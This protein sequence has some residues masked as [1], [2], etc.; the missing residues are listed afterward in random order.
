MQTLLQCMAVQVTAEPAA[1]AFRNLC[2]RCTSKLQDGGIL[3][4]LID[5]VKGLL[6]QG[7]PPSALLHQSNAVGSSERMKL[8]VFQGCLCL[9]LCT[10]RINGHGAAGSD[11]TSKNWRRDLVEGLARAASQLPYEQ[12]SAAA[13]RIVG[14]I[15]DTLDRLA[16]GVSGNRA[17]R[18]ICCSKRFCICR[19]SF[20]VSLHTQMI[21]YASFSAPSAQTLPPQQKVSLVGASRGVLSLQLAHRAER[22]KILWSSWAVWPPCCIS[23]KAGP[24]RM[25]RAGL[26]TPL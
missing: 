20:R 21:S 11:G 16:T 1:A 18:A 25:G 10:R 4:T 19:L 2:V 22:G 14:P 7:E 24:Q 5:A 13:L 23:L 26:R 17:Q 6:V 3:F 12:A 8:S 9:F 15:V